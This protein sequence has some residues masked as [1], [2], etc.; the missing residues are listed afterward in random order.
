MSEVCERLRLTLTFMGHLYKALHYVINRMF[1]D[2]AQMGSWWCKAVI[3][4]QLP[5]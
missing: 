3:L 5:V 2:F 4:C 1:A